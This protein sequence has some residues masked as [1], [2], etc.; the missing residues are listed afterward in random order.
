M[1]NIVLQL[2]TLFLVCLF[3]SICESAQAKYFFEPMLSYQQGQQDFQY[4]VTVPVF[5][6]QSAKSAINGWGLGFGIGMKLENK[7]S[8]GIDAQ[9]HFL[10]VGSNSVSN[11]STSSKQFSEYIFAGYD[12]APKFNLYFGLGAMQA[13]NDTTPASTDTASAAKIGLSYA[14]KEPYVGFVEAATFTMG[15]NTANGITTRY[16][17]T[18][19]NFS[20]S[21]LSVGVKYPFSF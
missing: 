10:N 11:S 7:I 19:K 2:K 5:G 8:I 9:A 15:S 1:T 3:I 21:V 6:G 18:Y 13:Q 16:D 20:Y 4:E 14:E 12:V 17:A